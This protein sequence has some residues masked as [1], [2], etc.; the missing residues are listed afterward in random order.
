MTVGKE[1][2]RTGSWI[3]PQYMIGD[4]RRQQPR[5][6]RS[7]QQSG[8]K[9]G[10]CRFWKQSERGKTCWVIR[11]RSPSLNAADKSRN[12][13]AE[14]WPVGV[15]NVKAIEAWSVVLAEWWGRHLPELKTL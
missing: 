11:Q 6:L 5:S 7:D 9:A 4:R 13:D 15:K 10:K 14:N 12:I 2:A 8:K 1:G 3:P